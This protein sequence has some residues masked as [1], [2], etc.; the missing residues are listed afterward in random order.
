[1]RRGNGWKWGNQD[2]GE[3]GTVVTKLTESLTVIVRWSHG[4]INHYRIGAEGGIF[5]VEQVQRQKT[6]AGSGDV[7]SAETQAAAEVDA[8]LLDVGSSE[9][10]QQDDGDVT[11]TAAKERHL[12]PPG[13][14]LQ[15][16]GFATS[17]IDGAHAGATISSLPSGAEEMPEFATTAGSSLVTPAS[18]ALLPRQVAF[19]L[20]RLGNALPSGTTLGFDWD[21][22]TGNLKFL[23]DR[24]GTASLQI[25]IGGAGDAFQSGQ[26]ASPGPR[27]GWSVAMT[28]TTR[29]V[30]LP[31]QGGSSVIVGGLELLSPA[32]AASPG[33]GE[34]V[35]EV[36][37]DV[38]EP[39][40]GAGGGAASNRK[41][42]QKLIKVLLDRTS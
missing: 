28:V 39:V 21:P 11:A 9:I 37:E 27:S 38:L 36:V 42:G 31:A 32:T 12:L 13:L 35:A 26:A 8:T 25:G 17:S 19:G 18:D 30:D 34:G 5:D 7:D 29:R 23:C 40:A 33:E 4:G 22:S 15:I 3:L 2:R 24:V 14:F 1:M 41:M 20:F 10:S 6:A 16:R